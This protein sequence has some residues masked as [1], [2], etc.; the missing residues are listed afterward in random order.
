MD[1]NGRRRE[2]AAQIT[3]P[4][5]RRLSTATVL[6]H[7]AVAEW[8]GLGPTDHKCLDLLLDRGPLTGSQL[9]AITGLT[10]GAVTGVATRLE[11]AGFVR[12]QPDPLDRRK[13]LL[14]P[15][16]E[17][18]EAARAVFAA[19][20]PAPDT[21]VEGFDLAQLEAIARYLGRVAAFN[22]ERAAALRAQLLA[23]GGAVR[24]GARS[25][26]PP[27]TPGRAHGDRR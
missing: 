20:G 16:P 22:L 10:T 5:A 2:L 9:A 13:Q 8:L 7:H 11:R 12:R 15:V 3:G 26:P 19:A 24:G 6:F 17:R 14:T 27:T 1:E 21:L 25:A 4:L 23:Q 18:I